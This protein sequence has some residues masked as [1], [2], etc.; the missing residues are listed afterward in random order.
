V[1][2][3]RF[4]IVILALVA[5]CSANELSAKPFKGPLKVHPQNPRYFTDASGK[6]IY[7]T[8]SH[9]WANMN[10]LGCT[11]PPPVFDWKKYLDFMTGHNHNFIR[12]WHSE[13]TMVLGAED[14]AKLSGNY[15]I[16]PLI[17]NRTGPGMALDGK[18]KIDLAKFNQAWFDRIRQRAID[19][20]KR[21]LYIS[22]MLFQ[23]W[24]VGGKNKDNDNAFYGHPF[25]SANNINGIN[26][27]P[28]NDGQGLEIH[29]LQVPAITAIQKK[30]VKKVIDELNDLDNII[31]EI[32]NECGKHSAKWQYHMIDFIKSYEAA[33]K[34][35]QHLVWMSSYDI[36][37]S[38]LFAKDCH[39]DVVAPGRQVTNF[40]DP[41]EAHFNKIV[42][43]DTDHLWGIGGT[44]KWVWV[45]F[46]RGYHPIFMDVIVTFNPKRNPMDPQWI[47]LRKAMGHTRIYAEK[48]NLAKATPQSVLSSTTYCLGQPGVEYLFYQPDPGKDFIGRPQ[49]G[50]YYYE[51]FNP[52]IGKV[53]EKGK[54]RIAENEKYFTNPHKETA[55]LY[56]KRLQNTE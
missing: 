36:P 8:G 17:Y 37:D 29:T 14:C 49:V 45:S 38:V 11:D 31:W 50:S 27:D 41:P 6:A 33:K 15:Y 25:N 13:N 21:G 47:A 46:I 55:V 30:Y 24:S 56:L 40:R 28:N 53:T 51:W 18:P 34:P 20:G 22:I 16:F 52:E 4:I 1:S 9:N 23:G 44:A 10:D 35:K 54:V 26:G 42:I 43:L 7:L 5:T 32:G 12:G 19:A 39:A 48:M 2:I 3:T